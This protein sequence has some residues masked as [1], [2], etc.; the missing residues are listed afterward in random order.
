MFRTVIFSRS[1]A[2]ISPFSCIFFSRN[3]AILYMTSL[4]SVLIFSLFLP[5]KMCQ[6]V[7]QFPAM[8]TATPAVNMPK[9]TSMHTVPINHFIVSIL[10]FHESFILTLKKHSY[11]ILHSAMQTASSSIAKYASAASLLTIRISPASL[12][13]IWIGARYRLISMHRFWSGHWLIN[14]P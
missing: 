13:P 8:V 10:P 5:K 7:W 9:R 3:S 12:S 14:P 4:A 1:S 6:S 11:I 2:L